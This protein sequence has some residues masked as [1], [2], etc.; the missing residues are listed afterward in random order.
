V[1]S[2]IGVDF[3]GEYYPEAQAVIH[4][5]DPFPPA[6]ADLS[7]GANEVF[8][9]AVALLVSP[10]TLFS[11]GLASDLACVLLVAALVATLRLLGVTDWRV[12]CLTF[13]WPATVSTIQTANLTIPLGLLLAVAWRYRRHRWLPGIA[14]GVAVA[15]KFY[16]WPFVLLLLATRRFASATTAVAITAASLVL[17]LPFTSLTSYARLMH[18]MASTFGPGS[19]TPIGLLDHL[20][21]PSTLVYP[22]AYLVGGATLLVALARKSIPLTLLAS[23]LLSPIVWLHYFV[24]LVVPL[25]L[26]WPRLAAPWLLPLVL[27]ACPGTATYAGADQ[28]L[29]ALVVLVVVVVL[30]GKHAHARGLPVSPGPLSLCSAS[31]A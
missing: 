17:I 15:L 31:A 13:G 26:R 21:A 16:L 4:G 23:L 20:G 24:L 12:Y 18:T 7:G 11:P 19:Y 1:P 27:W 22:I 6:S 3:R 5:H 28:I 10:L 8:P 30:S 25:G 14:V 2:H 29:I 9:V